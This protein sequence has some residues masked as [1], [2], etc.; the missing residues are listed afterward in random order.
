MTVIHLD[1]DL[2]AH[3][4]PVDVEH[5]TVGL[6]DR[7][8]HEVTVAHVYLLLQPLGLPNILWTQTSIST[9]RKEKIKCVLT[10]KFI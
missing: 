4:V 7:L 6:T 3:T 5:V 10:C 1:A 8:L 9:Q 2:V